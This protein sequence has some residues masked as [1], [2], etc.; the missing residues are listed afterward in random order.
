M[1]VSLSKP[2]RCSCFFS[3]QQPLPSTHPIR[4]GEHGVPSALCPSHNEEVTA[5]S[6]CEPTAC[7]Q[8]PR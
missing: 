4:P 7:Q 3:I 8:P 2:Q 1:R 6:P 5:T